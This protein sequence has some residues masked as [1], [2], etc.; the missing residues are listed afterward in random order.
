MPSL[1]R[2]GW[3]PGALSCSFYRAGFP[4]CLASFQGTS[5]ETKRLW[6][7]KSKTLLEFSKLP[8]HLLAALEIDWETLGRISTASAVIKP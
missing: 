5:K 7:V 4:I 2:P 3:I 1:V 8:L 6:Y